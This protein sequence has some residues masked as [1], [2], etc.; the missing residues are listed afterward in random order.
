MTKIIHL[1][2]PNQKMKL[3][4]IL[5]GL[6]KIRI[7]YSKGN[8]DTDKLIEINRIIKEIKEYVPNHIFNW[9]GN[10]GNRYEETI[11][12]IMSDELNILHQRID[13]LEELLH[14]ALGP[15]P[16]CTGSGMIYDQD[17]DA[18]RDLTLPCDTCKGTG[19]MPLDLA[20]MMEQFK[21]QAKKEVEMPEELPF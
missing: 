2:N 11:K 8:T 14:T 5:E 9:G 17:E 6:D 10:M 18:G 21:V 7:E 20:D 13:K 19:K 12:E 4:L 3:E 1:L 15:C 16:R